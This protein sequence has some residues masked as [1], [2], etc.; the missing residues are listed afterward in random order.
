MERI[1]AD[2]KSR[3]GGRDIF[4]WSSHAS[5]ILN[6]KV[7]RL[8]HLLVHREEMEMAH[9]PPL[10]STFSVESQTTTIRLPL[11]GYGGSILVESRKNGQKGRG[12]IWWNYLV[13]II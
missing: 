2:N 12:V 11:V 3:V 9:G 1:A 10:F 8:L 5:C 6:N 4:A 7:P 13:G